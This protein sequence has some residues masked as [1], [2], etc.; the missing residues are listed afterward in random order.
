MCCN[1]IYCIFVI[2]MKTDLK[3]IGR[4]LSHSLVVCGLICNVLVGLIGI[5][6]GDYIL[7]I[8]CSI[9]AIVSLAGIAL[10]FT[11]YARLGIHLVVLSYLLVFII[12]SFTHIVSYSLLLIYPILIGFVSLNFKKQKTQNLYVLLVICG[13]AISIIN[14]QLFI[15]NGANMYHLVGSLIIG[16]GLIVGFAITMKAHVKKLEN[17]RDQRDEI[18]SSMIDKNIALQEYIKTNLQLE[19]FA[20]LA[21]HELKT[22][23][24]NISNFSQ[25]LDK[26]M[27]GK[28]D[29]KNQEILD[30]IKEESQRMSGMMADLL[31]LSQLASRNIEYQKING[32]K[33]IND[34]VEDNFFL[35]KGFIAVNS[36][37]L[38]LFA[39]EAHLHILFY[40]IVENAIKFCGGNEEPKI[41][42]FGRRSHEYYYFEVKDNGIGID[43]KYKQSV[44][45]I[46]KKLN[47]NF[48]VNGTGIGL[49]MCR[50]I[51][52]RHNGRI[53]IEDN[54][55]GGTVVKFTLKRTQTPKATE[56]QLTGEFKSL[57]MRTA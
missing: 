28:L 19:N 15:F 39:A 13:S 50:E 14:T 53:W 43:D 22:P 16:I 1:G 6:I 23:I 25:L 33:F 30:M 52:E 54:S 34:L 49:S 7:A 40:N 5:S 51:V 48:N 2:T 4:Q 3:N 47:P 55:E 12:A 46:F 18:E 57:E 24:K 37:P 45:L 17:Y 44:F 9:L 11:K 20:H 26:R 42:I 31:K 8:F 21:S 32:H 29:A 36:F 27:E 35:D 41:T 38:E 56:E 10:A